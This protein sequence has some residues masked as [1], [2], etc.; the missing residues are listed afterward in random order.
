MTRCAS[1]HEKVDE[2]LAWR[3]PSSLTVRVE[4]PRLVIRSR[5]LEDGPALFEAINASR[6]RLLPW[7]PWARTDHFDLAST[8]EYL[9]GRISTAQDPSQLIGEGA[10]RGF[11][12]GIFEREGACVGGTG[13]NDV[14]PSTASAET[15]YWIRGDCHGRGYCTEAMR[16]WISWL[17]RPQDAGGLGLQRLRIYCSSA[18]K[19]SQRIPQKLGLRQEVMQRADY[20][21]PDVGVTDRLGWG[22]LADEWDCDRH[23]MRQ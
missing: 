18:N 4:T 5:T 14:R 20:Y 11:D 6:D 21:V 1:E 10:Q 3:P 23:A 15:G 8:T 2:G 16:H 9:A 19:A 13:F 12:V 22:V 17:L 7:M